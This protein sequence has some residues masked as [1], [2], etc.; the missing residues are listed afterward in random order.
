MTTICMSFHHLYYTMQCKT[1]CYMSVEMGV[2]S[3]QQLQHN[4]SYMGTG[5]RLGSIHRCL[6][7]VNGQALA[8]VHTFILQQYPKE[9]DEG[10]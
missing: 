7:I 10:K 3:V 1:S 4:N 8:A 2:T 9:K 6:T 5:S